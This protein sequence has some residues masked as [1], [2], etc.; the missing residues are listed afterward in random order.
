MLSN[1]QGEHIMQVEERIRQEFTPLA[2][3]TRRHADK[4]AEHHGKVFAD[5]ICWLT[6]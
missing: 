4:A 2:I 3:H 6:P 1:T 5:R